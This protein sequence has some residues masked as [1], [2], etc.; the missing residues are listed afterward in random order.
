MVLMGRLT[1][2]ELWLFWAVPIQKQAGSDIFFFFFFSQHFPG[3]Y[4]GKSTGTMRYKLEFRTCFI[5][6]GNRA[7]G[8]LI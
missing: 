1:L 7:V 3:K 2:R 8:R 4:V 6:S 5:P